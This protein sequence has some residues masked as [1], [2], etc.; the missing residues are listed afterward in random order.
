MSFLGRLMSYLAN[1]VVVKSLASSPAFQRWAVRTNQRMVSN[2][3]QAAKITH[4]LKQRAQSAEFQNEVR[5]GLKEFANAVRRDFSG[6]RP[7]R[8]K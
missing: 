3:E 1:E 2:A 5:Q 4:G 6:G 8:A 7:P